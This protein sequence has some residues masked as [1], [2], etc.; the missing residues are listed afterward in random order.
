M[1]VLADTGN[2]TKKPLNCAVKPFMG[3]VPK[4]WLKPLSR[5]NVGEQPV[6]AEVESADFNGCD[7]PM[8]SVVRDLLAN[9]LLDAVEESFAHRSRKVRKWLNGKIARDALLHL[10]ICPD[11]A[12]A[13]LRGKWEEIDRQAQPLEILGIN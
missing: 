13:S 5:R 9:V 10:D 3:I 7:D 1:C 11:E 6:A 8:R 12:L 4:R 2:K